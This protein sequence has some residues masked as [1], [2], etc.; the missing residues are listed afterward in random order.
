MIQTGRR[1]AARSA[2]EDLRSYIGVTFQFANRQRRDP[3]RNFKFD[4]NGFVAT[5]HT[6][7]REFAFAHPLPHSRE[8]QT[9]AIENFCLCQQ[10]DGTVGITIAITTITAI[11]AGYLVGAMRW[12]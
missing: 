11:A 8:T 3:F 12:M 5:Q 6:R 9:N 4:P 2:L 7:A 1:L 10:T